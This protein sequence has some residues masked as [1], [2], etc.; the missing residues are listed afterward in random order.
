MISSR[1]RIQA[2][3]IL[4][5]SSTSCTDRQWDEVPAVDVEERAPSSN[6]FGPQVVEVVSSKETYL[7]DYL[8][9]HH[10]TPVTKPL[11]RPDARISVA[12]ETSRFPEQPHS[13][14][15]YSLSSDGKYSTLSKSSIDVPKFS[16]VQSRDGET[17]S[18]LREAVRFSDWSTADMICMQMLTKCQLRDADAVLNMIG[19]YSSVSQPNSVASEAATVTGSRDEEKEA[20]PVRF[21]PHITVIEP[22]RTGD[23]LSEQVDSG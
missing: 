5:F 2:P 11:P 21:S 18:R 17:I 3:A 19:N 10:V 20:S 13:D 14:S 1:S 6:L 4:D 23:Y 8:R 7:P 15:K 12:V 22:K 9:R 16:P